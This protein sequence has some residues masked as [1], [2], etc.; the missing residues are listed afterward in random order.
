MP[1]GHIR[2]YEDLVEEAQ[3]KRIKITRKQRQQ[4]ARMYEEISKD[5]GKNL[6]GK[7]EKTLT[8]RW[9]KDYAKSLKG[10][11]KT[12]Y[13]ELQGIVSNS[14]LNTAKA[15]TSAQ[16]AFWGKINP[17][18]SEQFRDVFSAIPQSCVDELMNGGIYK[19]FAGLSERLW[20][21][22][23]KFNWDIGYV[24]NRGI[25]EKKSA[26]DLAKDLER[27]LKPGVTKPWSWRKVYPNSNQIVDYNT[28]RLARTSVTH[29]Y[30]ISLQRST[31]NNPF[32]EKYQWH[33]S[34]SGRVCPLCLSRDGQLYEKDDVP[35]DHPNGMCI[36]T[37]VIS[38]SYEQIADELA[39]W[40]RGGKNPA[41][42]RWLGGIN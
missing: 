41:L 2:Q 11:S 4:I 16:E 14:I 27:Y 22:Q 19:D 34:N 17:L 12:I 6:E 20:N 1:Y 18:L 13:T 25:I 9:I 7:S 26:F 32:I 33:S 38:K 35:L 29:A 28:Q 24:I 39:D 36:I 42:D 8:Y 37:A 3:A 15:V 21:Y 5:F 10:E 31:R 40:A 23:E 30:Q